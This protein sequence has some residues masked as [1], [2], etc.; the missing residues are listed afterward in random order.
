MKGRSNDPVGALAAKGDT[1]RRH[2]GSSEGGRFFTEHQ[3]Y[4]G[5]A[6]RAKSPEPA[7]AVG[8]DHI[9]LDSEH[10]GLKTGFKKVAGNGVAALAGKAHHAPAPAM[11]SAAALPGPEPGWERGAARVRAGPADGLSE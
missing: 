5:R 10:G 6:H 3:V 4:L 7:G 2:R 11:F 1:A 9:R 8:D